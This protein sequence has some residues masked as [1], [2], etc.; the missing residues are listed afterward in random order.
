MS[1]DNAVSSTGLE[2]HLV[3]LLDALE[4]AAAAL[5]ALLSA[6]DIRADFFVTSSQRPAT[7][8]RRC[9]QKR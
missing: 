4:P 7:E 9:L 3:H 1:T 6:E 2:H 8:D 5:P